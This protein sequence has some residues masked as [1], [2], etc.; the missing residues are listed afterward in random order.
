VEYLPEHYQTTDYIKEKNGLFRA[1][2]HFAYQDQEQYWRVKDELVAYIAKHPGQFDKYLA[3]KGDQDAIEV[4]DHL[5][6]LSNG[7]SI[8]GAELAAFSELYKLNLVVVSKK[9]GS[10]AAHQHVADPSNNEFKGVILQDGHYQ[11]LTH[12]KNPTIEIKS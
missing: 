1:L 4:D 2:A 3:K 7:D 9:G 11:L 12:S 8:D 6:R 5:Y 10:V